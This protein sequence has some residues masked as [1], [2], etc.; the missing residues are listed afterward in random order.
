MPRK[1]R[2]HVPGGIYHVTL[3]GN[4]RQRIFRREADR[5]RLDEIVQTALARSGARLHAFVWMTNHIHL[6]VQ[7]GDPPLGSLMQR[8][9]TRF[10]RAMQK[11]MR[12]TGHMFERRYHAL[13][14]DVDGYFLEL[15]RYIH[16]NP[17]RARMVASPEQYPWSSHHDYL[18]AQ[19]RDWITTEFALRMFSADASR[20]RELYRTFVAERIGAPTEPSLYRGHPKES[21][22]LGDDQFLAKLNVPPVRRDPCVTLEQI[23]TQVC[24]EFDV[25]LGALRSPARKR[26]LTR[27]RALIA[28]R[29]VD[30]HVATLSEAARFLHRSVS[31][32]SRS[33]DRQR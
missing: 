28:T 16:L 32:L 11:K 10:A 18:A 13:L 15:L 12:T 1:P 8:I 29:V 4:H 2:L 7:V 31:A 23:C 24:R 22:I 27:A 14:V 21:R 33:V 26:A 19:P 9:G 5:D 20:A 17:V 30:E 25:T 6:L 3:R